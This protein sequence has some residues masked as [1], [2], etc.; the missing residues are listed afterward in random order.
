[1][2]QALTALPG[3]LRD[4]GLITLL[5][6][7]AILPGLLTMPVLDRDEARYAQ[8]SAQ[9][10]ESNNPIEIRFQDAPRHRKPVGIYWLQAA[11]T[12]LISSAEAREIAS[13][14]L[15]S[16]AAAI[17]AALA[18][19]GAG[20]ALAGR[21]TGLIAG[22]LLAVSVLLASEG[23]IAKTDAAL[24]AACALA[25]LSLVKVRLAAGT[26]ED[27][28]ARP[29]FWAVTGWAAIA[30]GI[31]IKGP[32]APLAMGSAV[33]VLTVWER[34]W[35]WWRHYLGWRGP[36]LAAAIVLPWLVA[37]QIATGGEFLASWF[38]NDLAPKLVSGHEGHG[39]P[40]GSHTLLLGLLLFPA[41][42]AL[43][44][45]LYRAGAALAGRS[46]DALPARLLLVWTVP[47]LI[48][49]ELLPTKLPHYPLPLYPALAV[50]AA[51]GAVSLP[52]Q[53][54]WTRFA[55]A[56][57]ALVG[58]A[59]LSLLMGALAIG[60]DGP[61]SAALLFALTVMALA[62]G[63]TTLWINAHA[64]SAIAVLI[65]AALV[66]HTGARAIVAPQ[67]EGLF[68]TQAVEREL[69]AHALLGPDTVILSTYTE[70]SLVFALEGRPQ[71]L[72]TAG[73]QAALA[74]PAPDRVVLFDTSRAGPEA[75]AVL[76]TLEA[77]ACA[78]HGVEGFNYSRG[79]HTSVFIFRLGS[80]PPSEDTP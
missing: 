58:A 39:A 13:Y 55:G 80:C 22:A 70:P 45:G 78:R 18:T 8:S 12:G 41:S 64:I 23:A 14:R 32:V 59:V 65:A 4:T 27:P 57:L 50:L 16:L 15:P 42:L 43:P 30:A 2:R 20:C 33:L 24:A 46:G 9:M 79:T 60:S 17:V 75:D 6:V 47:L 19:W 63:A 76:A 40:P 10:L 72:D 66:W 3:W 51:W 29:G 68:L 36:A 1:M 26:P 34:R 37:I 48:F 73:L 62:A 21:R 25:F 7:A 74:R 53:P 49:F 35:D 11:S 56:A 54:V 31:L 77:R 61:V 28:G 5:A 67:S 38:G 44:A 69:E 71:L 52:A